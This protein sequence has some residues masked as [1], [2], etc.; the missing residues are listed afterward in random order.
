MPLPFPPSIGPQA[1]E[2]NPPINPQ[3]YQ[4]SIFNISALALGVNTLVTTSVN[5]NYVLGQNVR[6]L[7]PNTYGSFQLSEQQGL[8]ISIPAPNQVLVNINSVG[9]DTFIPS[10]AYGPTKPQIV[11]IGDVNSGP[12]N[13]SGRQNTGTFI[14]G[15]FI[16]ISPL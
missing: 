8:V 4:P 16:N 13:A 11:A 7:I 10:P 3:F 6:L 14:Q 5:H 2:R 12:I 15:S 1:P 9:A